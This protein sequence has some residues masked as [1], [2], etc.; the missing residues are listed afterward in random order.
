[1][2]IKQ[3][4]KN[5]TTEHTHTGRR[6]FITGLLA[7]GFAMAVRP[8]SA[9][10]IF[11]D[12]SGITSEE[13]S[14]PTADISI[15]AYLAK[16]TRAGSFP[17]VL[18][19]Q[20]IFGVHEH[21][22]DV[23][24]RLAKLGYT[25]IAPE[26]FIRQGDVS[27]ISDMKE[28][29]SK[30]VSKVPDKQVMQDLDATVKWMA[31]HQQGDTSRL[32]ITGFCWGGRITWLYCAHNPNVRT[33]IAWYG[34]LE[35]QVTE[36]QPQYPIDIATSL[37]TPVLGLYGANDQSIPTA[38]VEHMRQLLKATGN[39][40]EIMLYPDAGHAFFADYR[41]SYKAEIAANAWLKLQVWLAS[42][43]S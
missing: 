20:E 25:A 26:L 8:I 27:Q 35:G 16:P 33:G 39:G 6:G 5:Q 19:M 29:I 37:K 41:P 1:M 21:I 4:N 18:V 12:S 40:S 43:L 7:T 28:I 32:G 24:R 13:V 22:R 23:C 31:D 14:I 42:H 10:T 3:S 38:N 30:V 34:K 9:E 11:T 15:P 36:L 17:V 2:P